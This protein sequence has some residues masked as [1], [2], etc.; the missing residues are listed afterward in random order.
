MHVPEK[1]SLSRQAR[2]GQGTARSTGYL[3]N[4]RNLWQLEPRASAQLS[5]G[6][7]DGQVTVDANI[8]RGLSLKN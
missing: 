4:S 3:A 2:G 5:L 7:K 6:E 8:S 1:L